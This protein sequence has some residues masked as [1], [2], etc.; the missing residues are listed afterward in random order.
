M[1]GLVELLNGNGKRRRENGRR[2]EREKGKARTEKNRK[3][4]KCMV[5]G[6]YR[7]DIINEGC[8][9]KTNHSKLVFLTPL[10]SIP[11]MLVRI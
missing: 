3:E 5:E 7:V 6:T 10:S 11:I 4:K 9:P 8:Q 1:I 2:K